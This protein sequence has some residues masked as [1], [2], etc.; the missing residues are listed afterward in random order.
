MVSRALK[1][2]RNKQPRGAIMK[3]TTFTKIE[4][5]CE[6]RG[7]SEESCKKQAGSVYWKTA[8]RK[9]NKKGG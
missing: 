3:P 6:A 2:W 1:E 7:G 8:K 4:K 9:F 5:S